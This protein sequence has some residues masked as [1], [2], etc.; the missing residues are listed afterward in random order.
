MKQTKKQTTTTK[1]KTFKRTQKKT[2]DRKRRTT[3]RTIKERKMTRIGA[4][5]EEIKQG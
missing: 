5:K 2:T 3:T 1:M 4:M